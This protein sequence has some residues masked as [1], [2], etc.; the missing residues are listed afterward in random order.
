MLGDEEVAAS[1]GQRLVCVWAYG[2]VAGALKGHNG[3]AQGN[4]LGM[5][6]PQTQ[7]L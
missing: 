3:I 6:R 7:A 5:R 4:A 1:A 2:C